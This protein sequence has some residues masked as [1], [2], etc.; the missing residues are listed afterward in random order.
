MSAQSFRSLSTL[1]AA[2]YVIAM[3]VAAATNPVG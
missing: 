1:I 3:L 2:V